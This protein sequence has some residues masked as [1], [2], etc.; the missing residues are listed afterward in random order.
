MAF[1]LG[2]SSQRLYMSEAG[3]EGR[4]VTIVT[5]QRCSSSLHAH[6][7]YEIDPHIYLLRYFVKYS[8]K[9]FKCL[10]YFSLTEWKIYFVSV[11][12]PTQMPLW[13]WRGFYSCFKLK[14]F[15]PHRSLKYPGAKV[16]RHCLITNQSKYLGKI[17][18]GFI[19]NFIAT[20][21]AANF[22]SK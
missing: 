20:G 16:N 19:F 1:L 10:C 11:K 12:Y 3:T 4:N 5:L 9:L 15:K 18:T 7:S 17:F 22:I 8:S 13:M 2:F 21:C 6:F 14:S